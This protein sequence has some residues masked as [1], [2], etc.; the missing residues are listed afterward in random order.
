[1]AANVAV[2]DL[3]LHLPTVPVTLVEP[4]ALSEH[5]GTKIT[6]ASE[7]F[8]H[9]GS[10]KFRAAYNVAANVPQQKLITAS[11]GNFGQALA[12]ACK[13]LKKQCIVVMPT[14]SA[15]IKI[16]AVRSHGAEVELVDTK[17]KSR[18]ERLAEVAALHPDAYVTSAYD[19]ALV[20]DGNATLGAEL[21]SAPQSWDCIV[22]PIGG[23]GLISGVAQG[24]RRAGDK[25]EIIGAEPALGNDAARSL[26]CGELVKNASEPPTIADG[27]RTLSLG[28]RNW[29]I[30][31]REVNDIL[32]VSEEA[33]AEAV[34]V[35]FRY[36]NLKAEPTGALSLAAVMQHR[37]NFA[38]RKVCCVISGGNVDPLVYSQLLEEGEQK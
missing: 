35:L 21:A 5:V 20:I 17:I 11:S 26:R 7:T 29:E 34:R 19:D 22:A 4:R 38:G 13:L 14:I 32:E 9:T 30:I 2:T 28:Q 18:A 33:I 3:A 10:F 36:A 15:K 25:T 1:M 8:Q 12:Y 23:G 31:R 6:L 37:R 27:A 16:A 24:L